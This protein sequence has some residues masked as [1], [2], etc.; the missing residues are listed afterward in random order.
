M[1]EPAARLLLKLNQ[2]TKNESIHIIQA[3]DQCDIKKVEVI[4][5]I[6]EICIKSPEN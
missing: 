1:K 2:I 3:L 5:L 6:Y 4:D